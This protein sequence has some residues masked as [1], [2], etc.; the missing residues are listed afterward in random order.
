[1]AQQ[2]DKTPD[3]KVCLIAHDDELHEA[4]LSLRSWHRT[5]VTKYFV[6]T[7]EEEPEE[8]FTAA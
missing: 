5:Q 2:T 6:D 7:E 4:T 3:C 8:V 1:M